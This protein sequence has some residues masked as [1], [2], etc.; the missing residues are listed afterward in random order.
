MDGEYIRFGNDENNLYRI[1]S[2]ENGAGT[3]IVSEKPLKSSGT[4]I[5]SAFGSSSGEVNY[6]TAVSDATIK[7]SD[8]GRNLWDLVSYQPGN[9]ERGSRSD[10][11][12]NS[13]FHKR[14]WE[15]YL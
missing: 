4:F 6:S 12:R 9:A 10:Q 1:V 11:G 14:T 8:R 7:E 3:K 15:K 13:V 5:T 2:H